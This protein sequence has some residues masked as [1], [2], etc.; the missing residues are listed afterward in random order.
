[1]SPSQ[2]MF[3]R[4]VPEY[5]DGA[6]GDVATVEALLSMAGRTK[7]SREG[8][9]TFLLLILL[10]GFF[11]LIFVHICLGYISYIGYIYDQL[12]EPWP[13]G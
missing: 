5:I 13:R 7:E 11:F 1:M 12:S 2:F 8:E 9:N 6:D 10:T 4:L 3:H